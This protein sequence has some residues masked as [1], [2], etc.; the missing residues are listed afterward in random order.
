MPDWVHWPQAQG[1]PD[2]ADKK[3]RPKKETR[4]LESLPHSNHSKI[5]HI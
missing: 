5:Q 1:S 4:L 3:A 2:K